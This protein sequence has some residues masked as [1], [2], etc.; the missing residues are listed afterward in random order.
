MNYSG[1]SNSVSSPAARHL[2]ETFRHDGNYSF[3]PRL[4]RRKEGKN[5]PKSTEAV[6]HVTRA[7]GHVTGADFDGGV[8]SDL[9][10]SIVW[11]C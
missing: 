1:W 4:F 3:T 7:V 11:F 5:P 8:M 10:L 9:V 6:S 2:H